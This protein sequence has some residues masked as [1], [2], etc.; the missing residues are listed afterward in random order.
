MGECGV[1]CLHLRPVTSSC[2][3]R[4]AS[5]QKAV[6]KW[7]DRSQPSLM[8]WIKVRWKV[9]TERWDSCGT[10]EAMRYSISRNLGLAHDFCCHLKLFR[11]AGQTGFIPGVYTEQ[12]TASMAVL[13]SAGIGDHVVCL[14]L[15]K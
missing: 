1:L 3:R 13:F 15:E 2:R 10:W 6:V 4:F 14:E 11:P 5:C 8:V 7:V 9:G 12:Q